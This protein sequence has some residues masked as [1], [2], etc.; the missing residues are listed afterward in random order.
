MCDFKWVSRSAYGGTCRP[1]KQYALTENLRLYLRWKIP[2]LGT[3][4]GVG[5]GKSAKLRAL[6]S[7]WQLKDSNQ[8][9]PVM[10]SPMSHT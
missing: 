2:F 4:A 6:G 1:L 5:R 8:P 3:A 7:F 9:P 10:A